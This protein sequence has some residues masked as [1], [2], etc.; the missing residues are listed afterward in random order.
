MTE[1]DQILDCRDET[2]KPR[3]PLEWWD[4]A[5][6]YFMASLTAEGIVRPE[7]AAAPGAH[8]VTKLS[9]HVRG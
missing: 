2:S 5:D 1:D 7:E 3:P 6:R 4:A 8:V 9:G